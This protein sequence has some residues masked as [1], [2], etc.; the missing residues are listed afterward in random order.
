ML[1]ENQENVMSAIQLKVFAF[2]RGIARLQ[3]ADSQME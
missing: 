1:S 2:M 3:N